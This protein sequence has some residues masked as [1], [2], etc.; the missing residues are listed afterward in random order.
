MLRLPS[1]Q[2]LWAV[3]KPLRNPLT[4]TLR[5]PLLNPLCHPQTR[6]VHVKPLNS[7]EPDCL[8]Y[9]CDEISCSNLTLRNRRVKRHKDIATLTPYIE[10]LLI[11]KPRK[12]S[13]KRGEYRSSVV[14]H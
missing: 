8:P 14:C 4:K 10:R 9:K 12:K 6:H 7:R 11:S 1:Q 13:A 3:Y 5:N 2:A